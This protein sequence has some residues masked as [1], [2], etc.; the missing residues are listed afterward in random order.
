MIWL[1]FCY[2]AAMEKILIQ[3]PSDQM[4]LVNSKDLESN[5][6]NT[7][8]E[9]IVK[10]KAELIKSDFFFLLSR[11]R[12]DSFRVFTSYI[13]QILLLLFLYV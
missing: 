2:L 11:P 4:K 10:H 3:P 5:D 13:G 7:L 6:D 8:L 1:P 12:I 9:D